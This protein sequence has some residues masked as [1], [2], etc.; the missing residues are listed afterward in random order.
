MADRQFDIEVLIKARNAAS[1]E[2]QKIAGHVKGLE[3]QIDGLSKANAEAT[4]TIDSLTKKLDTLGNKG[5]SSAQQ[6]DRA[7]RDLTNRLERLDKSINDVNKSADSLGKKRVNQLGKDASDNAVKVRQLYVE[8]ENLAKKL[9]TSK[10]APFQKD[11]VER[12][13]N[14]LQ[15]KLVKSGQKGAAE[16]AEARLAAEKN[17]NRRIISERSKLESEVGRAVQ[18][19]NRGAT[20]ALNESLAKIV[21]IRKNLRELGDRNVA[22]TIRDAFGL[23]VGRQGTEGLSGLSKSIQSVGLATRKEL[24]EI[25]RDARS[26]RLSELEGLANL[27][28]RTGDLTK[29]KKIGIEVE[30][31]RQRA[32]QEATKIEQQNVKELERLNQNLTESERKRT[33]D[34]IRNL[35]TQQDF[36]HNFQR[37]ME[38]V[39]NTVSR[40]RVV[41]NKQLRESENALVRFADRLLGVQRGARN[42]DTSFR[43]LAFATRG[44]AIAFVIKYAQA[45]TTSL[46]SLGG[47]ALAVA[48]SFVSA[49]AAIGGAFTA[50]V[51]Q[52]IPVVGL[53]LASVQR[54]GQ[55]IQAL[56]L[57]K[58][59][60]QRG[61]R[62]QQDN[63]KDAEDAQ[64]QLEQIANANESLANAQRDL[65]DAQRNLTDARK[66]AKRELEDLIRAE[67]DA[68]LAARG[69][70]LSQED[71]Q[72][73]LR[74]ALE[75]GDVAAIRSAQLD[76]TGASVDVADARVRAARAAQD[77]SRGRRG[78]VEGTERVRSARAQL[79]DAETRL[80]RATR[81]V[82]RANRQSAEEVAKNT[83]QQ[84]R[85][86][87]ILEHLTPTERRLYNA[88]Q[89]LQTV[90]KRAFRPI[91]DTIVDAFTDAINSVSDLLKDKDLL[92]DFQNLAGVIA[93]SI[94]KIANFGTSGES[95]SFFS[96]FINQAAKNLPKLT[97]DFILL[98]KVILRIGEAATPVFDYILQVFDEIARSLDKVTSNQS[99]LG[100]F[101][102]DAKEDLEAI[103]N[104]AKAVG[105]L[106]LAVFDPARDEGRSAITKLTRLIDDFAA[107]LKKN[108][109]DVRG[110]FDD[111][112][113]VTAALGRIVLALA[114]EVSLIFNPT[115]VEQFSDVVIRTFIP[116][117]G[118]AIRLMGFVTQTIQSLLDNDVVGFF[119]RIGFTVFLF[120]KG[121]DVLRK[122]LAS[123]SL[124]FAALL[125]TSTKG[126]GAFRPVTSALIILASVLSTLGVNMQDVSRIFNG[127]T[128]KI[129]A[130]FIGAGGLISVLSKGGEAWRAYKG[131]VA[132]QTAGAL[133]GFNGFKR[134]LA[135]GMSGIRAIFATNPLGLLITGISFALTALDLFNNKQDE[136]KITTQQLTDSIN[137]QTDAYRALR[138]QALDTKDAQLAVQSAELRLIEARE[139]RQEIEKKA[140]KDGKLT[141][142]ER[143]DNRQATIDEQQAEVDLTRAKRRLRDVR[144]DEKKTIK[145][146]Q[147]ESKKAVSTARENV[148]QI[149]DEKKASDDRLESLKTS[150]TNANRLYEAGVIPRSRVK[151]L[152][153]DLNKEQDKND[154]ITRKLKGANDRLN[155]AL[156]GAAKGFF[157]LGKNADAFGLTFS[158]VLKFLDKGA[159]KALG[160][161]GAKKVDIALE[162][163]KDSNYYISDFPEKRAQGGIIGGEGL[164][165]NTLIM[166][167]PGEGILNRHQ[168]PVVDAA[169]RMSGMMQGGLGELWSTIQTPHYMARGGFVQGAISRGLSSAAMNFARRLF[170]LGYNVTSAVRPG[171]VTS[172]GNP[173]QH[174]TG[175]ALDFGNSVNDLG[176]LWHLL[177]PIRRQF[178]QLLGPYGLYNGIKRFYDNALQADH[179][180]HIHI[181]F[182][183]AVTALLGQGEDTIGQIKFSNGPGGYMMRLMRAMTKRLRGAGNSFL[184]KKAAELGSDGDFNIDYGKVA[185][186]SLSAGKVNAIAGQALR[187]LGIR[188]QARD[189][190]EMLVKRAYIESTFNPNAVNN[191]DSNAARGT[192][193]KG[194]MQ[195]IDSTFRQYALRGHNA[196]F[197][198]LDEMLSAI[199]YMIAR[200]GKGNQGVALSSMLSRN[201]AGI[202]YASGGPVGLPSAGRNPFIARGKNKLTELFDSYVFTPLVKDFES[203]LKKIKNGNVVK[204]LSNL[205]AENGVLSRML[206]A[207]QNSAQEITDRVARGAV[208]IGARGRI[209]TTRT[210]RQQ[211]NAE[212][213]G[214]RQIQAGLLDARGDLSDARRAADN[215]V[216]KAEAD[217]RKARKSKDESAIKKAKDRLT[218]VKAGL[219]GVK[220]SQRE[221]ENSLATNAQD[222]LAKQ[223]EITQIAVDA[224]NKKIE[225]INDKASR[226][227]AQA[228]RTGRLADVVRGTTV[229]GVFSA[230]NLDRSALNTRGSAIN[231]Q[232]AA[233]IKQR[234]KAGALGQDDIVTSLNEQIKDLTVQLTENKLA[235]QQNTDAVHDANVNKI[236]SRS[237]FLTGV[238]SSAV[239]FFQ[240]L[241]SLTGVNQNSSIAKLLGSSSATLRSTNN[242]LIGELNTILA[243]LGRSG[244]SGTGSSLVNQLVSLS[245]LNTDNLTPE[246]KSRFEQL[247]SALIDNETAINANSEQIKGLTNTVGQAFETTS[248]QLFRE[249]VF[250]GAGGLLPE[251]QA[252]VPHMLEGGMVQKNGLFFLH[253]GEKVTPKHQVSTSNKEEHNWYV[254]SPTEIADPD[255]FATVFSF[256]KSTQ[257]A[258]Y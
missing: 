64:R 238:N 237:G 130:G 160:A 185:K 145:E 44:F 104:L 226:A 217:L 167:A 65:A 83:V 220:A 36:I 214:L 54:V 211:A 4:K 84:D 195:M 81:D 147:T 31:E 256:R 105:K 242:G 248:W 190:Q 249:A 155:D 85:L 88:F 258:N 67:R 201:R 213:R 196:I 113:R 48:D 149:K 171:A 137:A 116:A 164:M 184:N 120:T 57:K 252:K 222:I 32:A 163:V 205:T 16:Y 170:T 14:Q 161:F 107:K 59:I 43:D 21:D 77:A 112:G 173:S 90:Y 199:R 9:A 6:Q 255:Y 169:L 180:D 50:G 143:R 2:L 153:Q 207:L 100:G 70:A 239:S 15:E 193:S 218:K 47:E 98:A 135:A 51:L 45:L 221:V 125:G 35:K 243:S 94:R 229:G 46:I 131:T 20:Q 198:P 232:I 162:Y 246:A 68:R 92:S 93:D 175:D 236:L 179:M 247:I 176:K 26:M 19:A 233:L 62:N 39:Q 254:T 1:A 234:N 110:F 178:N 3:A 224:L 109:D 206:D 215:A 144:E 241:Q 245:S 133:S 5:R 37:D 156:R 250:N 177:F 106:F 165:D 56:N 183:N 225:S 27:A 200:Y 132:V 191:W 108:Q 240:G 111:A 72:R 159:N 227:F 168:M 53:L 99:K 192:P 126:A 87:Y 63:A 203:T 82:A 13:F 150:L 76:V 187:I 182:R 148:D 128:G 49:G 186:G 66:E 174:A 253:A 204:A 40:T 23:A 202:G 33:L 74:A 210:P 166:A 17:T 38:R 91:T 219:Q 55:V 152:E 119:A 235:L 24:A 140:N 121:L 73:N 11:A 194:L 96:F 52:A 208:R 101:F 244:V 154:G 157:Q 115:T 209:T 42:A 230:L 158:D 188:S 136:T 117:L 127:T 102:D 114:R 141:A 251:F 86:N 146:A 8:I 216:D 223:D 25:E 103:F 71:A 197:N 18:N 228:D 79:A 138:D 122:A 129:I 58:Q 257:R 30:I 34:N 7:Y 89:N 28:R 10:L 12:E 80:A 142:Q 29:L 78:G 97:D 231:N 22:K 60:D 189:W 172:S 139:R 61:A 75:G 95:R 212:L 123:I 41:D 151:Q 134:K 69:A 118:Q 181:G 124:T